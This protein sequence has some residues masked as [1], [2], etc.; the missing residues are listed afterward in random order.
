M[1]FFTTEWPGQRR[2]GTL[3]Q[4]RRGGLQGLH[5]GTDSSSFVHGKPGALIRRCWCGPCV[6]YHCSHQCHGGSVLALG[7][8]D[9]EERVLLQQLSRQWWSRPPANTVRSTVGSKACLAV[10]GKSVQ[11]MLQDPPTHDCA[12]DLNNIQAT[13]EKVQVA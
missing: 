1:G 10:V 7:A 6:G 9:L 2:L 11:F 3:V 8:E 12:L 5:E 13:I 4:R